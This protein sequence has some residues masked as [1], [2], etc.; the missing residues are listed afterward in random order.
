MADLPRRTFLA[1]AAA[2]TALASTTRAAAND[3]IVVGVMGMG[4]R[5]TGLS[6]TFASQPNVHV[7]YVCDPDPKRAGAAAEGLE[8]ANKPKPTIVED[9]RRILDDKSVDVLVC[10][11]PNH[12]HAPAGILGCAA[13]KHCYIEKPCSHTPREG[14]M[15]V[16]AA[17]K[18]NRVVQMGNQR[19]SWPKVQEAIQ[20]LHEGVI[21]R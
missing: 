18:H 5:G 19:R 16:A 6:K 21:G 7:A 14:E 9:F 11:A 15:L 3:K 17:R 4:G 12:W 10:A 8:K 1:T 20:K 13:G 2:T